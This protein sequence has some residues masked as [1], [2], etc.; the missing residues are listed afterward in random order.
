M[1]PEPAVGV[2]EPPENLRETFVPKFQPSTPPA[3]GC[4]PQIFTSIFA[5][6]AQPDPK[7]VTT[8]E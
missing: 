4:S 1:G 8:T 3:L 6:A 5:S 2:D 7:S